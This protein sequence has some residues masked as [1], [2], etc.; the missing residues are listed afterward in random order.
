MF[1]SK[2]SW[3]LSALFFLLLLLSSFPGSASE[4]IAPDP[5]WSLLL[6]S[7]H[8][9]PQ[10]TDPTFLVSVK[11]FSEH[12]EQELT[13]ALY[14]ADP[15]LSFCRFPARLTFLSKKLGFTLANDR[16]E[17]CP[18]LQNFL[19]HVPFQQLD[20]VFASEVLSSA[21]SMMGHIFFK[22]SGNNFRNVPV[23]HSLAY[24]TEITTLNPAKLIV[25]STMTGMPGF[26][27]VRPFED[28]LKHYKDKEQRNVWQLQLTASTEQ[29]HLLQLHIWELHQINLT[30]Y[31][32]SFN[33]A[34]LTLEMLAILNPDVLTER[35]L[36]VSPVDVVKAAHSHKMISQ[37]EI[38][39][40]DLWLY[41]ALRDS[42]PGSVINELDAWLYTQQQVTT[43]PPVSH[44]LATTYLAVAL[45][46]A[47]A[48]Q[49]LTTSDA[50]YLRQFFSAEQDFALDLSNYKHPAQTPQDSA[51]G[52][53]WRSSKNSKQW[54][55]N[56]LPAGHF[57]HS[58]NRQYLSESELQIAKTTLAWDTDTK[59]L[60]LDEFTL[61]SVRSLNPDTDLFPLWS[62]ELYLGYKPAYT[63]T[64]QSKSVGE[65]SGAAGKSYDL[66][67]DVISFAMLGT[68]LTSSLADS[69]AFIYGKAGISFNLASD[70]KLI[71]EYTTSS[72]K[73]GK[74]SD[75]Q[76]LSA[77]FSWF[78]DRDNS[79]T[80]RLAKAKT[81]ASEHTEFGL[82]FL[83]YF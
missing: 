49:Q 9:K 50:E 59:R 16:Y 82:E 17:H 73:T 30:Y 60:T 21:S 55:L 24:F 48:Q 32:Q 26:F 70:T 38:N 5:I 78:P 28:D 4:K 61:Y 31:F 75:Y 53:A 47:L 44:P 76:Q 81:Q 11:N 67:K 35:G 40:A 56:F 39:T 36:I 83:S 19:Q 18:E 69:Y 52:L 51:V 37:T 20:L 25:E 3:C 1:Y 33:C 77:L 68:G 12:A 22:A 63:T 6:H 27:S 2:Q 23:S 7:W 74:N 45:D 66:H 62:G 54:L 64:L 72:G 13:L 8:G 71:A 43:P 57:L 29:L 79:M 58:D 41:N 65:I 15:Q 14:K 42:I 34:T 46:T 10:I 80:L